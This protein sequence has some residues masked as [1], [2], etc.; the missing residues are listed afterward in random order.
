MEEQPMK[1]D[2]QLQHDVLEELEWRPSIDASKIGVAAANGVVTLTGTVPQYADKIEA[3]RIAKSVAGVKAVADDIDVQLVGTINDTAI[4]SAALSALKWHTW[5][6]NEKLKVTVRDGWIT[7]EG[8]VDWKYQRE[9]AS[10]A[11]CHLQGVKGVA[12]EIGITVRPQPKDIRKQIEA[13]FKRSAE[14]DARHVQVETRDNRV[15]LTG[16]VSNSAEREEA[17]RVAWAAP[18]VTAV[19]NQLTVGG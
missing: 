5:I 6:P 16:N 18:G 17:E 2:S 12:N 13:S 3:E 7:L 15:V 8:T 10:E 9:A 4:A 19:D 1:A 14:V 11:V